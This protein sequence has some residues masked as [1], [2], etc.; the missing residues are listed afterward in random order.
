MRGENKLVVVV[1]ACENGGVCFLTG[2]DPEGVDTSSLEASSRN[3]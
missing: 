3:R 2:G 1:P